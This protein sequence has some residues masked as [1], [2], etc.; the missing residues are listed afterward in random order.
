M[1]Y[2]DHRAVGSSRNIFK[3]IET[4]NPDETLLKGVIVKVLVDR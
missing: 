2:L 3:K 4:L 1:M